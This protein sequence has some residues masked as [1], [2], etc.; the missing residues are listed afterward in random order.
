MQ[1]VEHDCHAQAIW[2]WDRVSPYWTSI[3]THEPRCGDY[4]SESDAEQLFLLDINRAQGK[5]NHVHADGSYSVDWPGGRRYDLYYVA[6]LGWSEGMS[7]WVWERAQQVST[8]SI[9][10]S[11]Q[12]QGKLQESYRE[13]D[14]QILNMQT[15]EP[16]QKPNWPAAI[17]LGLAGGA[18]MFGA[19]AIFGG[20][21]AARVAAG[22]VGAVV[23]AVAGAKKRES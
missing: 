20:G 21:A 15:P 12:E 3:E 16:E 18:I 6:V 4:T 11:A 14:E 2:G 7:A 8:M 22:C 13:L 1:S 23:G 17:G 19:A 9:S 10:M 5:I